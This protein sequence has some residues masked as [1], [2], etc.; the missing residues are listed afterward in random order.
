MSDKRPRR[1]KN[2]E[3]ARAAILQAARALFAEQGYKATTI[4]AIAERAGVTKSLIHHHVG[5]KQDLWREVKRQLF[6]AYLEAQR[7]LILSKE[8]D[9]D[10]MADSLETYFRYLQKNPDLS[11]M[12]AWMTLEGEESFED[13]SRGLMELSMDRLKLAQDQGVVRPDLNPF[14]IMSTFFSMVEHWFHARCEYLTRHD[15][16]MSAA[17]LDEAYLSTI[18]T[19]M[20]D[21][22]CLIGPASPSSSASS[23]DEGSP[24]S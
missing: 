21:G 15:P 23:E 17:E 16:G 19:I 20:L 1:Q 6:G 13:L 3:A 24:R 12:M 2:P 14:F 9:R 11:R 5:N 10:L 22:M 4:G 18:K 8:A 7:Q